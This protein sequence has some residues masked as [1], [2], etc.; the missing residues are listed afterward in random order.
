MF[1]SF[2]MKCICVGWEP[3]ALPFDT[4]I[5]PHFA[6]FVKGFLKNF[7]FFF[8]ALD[9][10]SLAWYIYIIPHITLKVNSQDAQSFAGFFVQNDEQGLRRK[11]LG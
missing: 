4:Y 5:I 7:L 8:V 2:E 10:R 3:Y 6:P 1:F 11:K 9:V